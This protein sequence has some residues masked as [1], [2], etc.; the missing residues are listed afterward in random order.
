MN[1]VT[2]KL[3]EVLDFIQQTN[4]KIFSI[5]FTKRTTGEERQMT[6]RT[7]VEGHKVAAPSKPGLDFKKHDLISVFD[8]Q[9]QAYRSIP[10][11]GIFAIKQDGEWVDVESDL[12]D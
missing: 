5:K 8:M 1:T 4:G 2:M 9:K 12:T 11:E 6:C 10:I 3:S 7:G